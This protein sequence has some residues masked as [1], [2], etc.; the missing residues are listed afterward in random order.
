MLREGISAKVV[1]ERLD[2]SNI[3]ITMDIYSHVMPGL[4][5]AAA[6]KFD[7]A[8]ADSIPDRNRTS[9]EPSLTIR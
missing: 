2:H 7:R 9:E 4:Q 5:E 8:L 6:E 3:G 1:Q